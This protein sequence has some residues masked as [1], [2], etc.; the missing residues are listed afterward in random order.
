MNVETS[1]RLPKIRAGV[2]QRTKVRK[3]IH[4][5][6]RTSRMLRRLPWVNYLMHAGPGAY[7]RHLTPFT[8][9]KLFDACRRRWLM[10]HDRTTVA[11]LTTTK[12]S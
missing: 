8:L 2:H 6:V 11:Q 9:T 5:L 4:N 1:M 12:E 10:S 7:L 3:F